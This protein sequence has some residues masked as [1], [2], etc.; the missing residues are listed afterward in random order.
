MKFKILVTTLTDSGTDSDS[1]SKPHG[2]IV[3]QNMFTLH[4]LGL[5]SLLPI[6]VQDRNPNPYSSPSLAI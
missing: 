2:Y 6:Y 4:L 5:G 3:L 1:D